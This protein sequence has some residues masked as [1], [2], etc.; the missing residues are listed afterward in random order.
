[1]TTTCPDAFLSLTRRS[2]TLQTTQ[3]T[4]CRVSEVPRWGSC[5]TKRN[6]K[7]RN[8]GPNVIG[9]ILDLDLRNH[10]QAQTEHGFESFRGCYPFQ[11]NLSE[12]SCTCAGIDLICSKHLIVTFRNLVWRHGQPRIDN[13][14]QESWFTNITGSRF[15][16]IEGSQKRVGTHDFKS[17]KHFLSVPVMWTLQTITGARLWH[18]QHLHTLEIYHRHLHFQSAPNPPGANSGRIWG[19]FKMHDFTKTNVIW[20]ILWSGSIHNITYKRFCLWGHS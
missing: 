13:R 2:K 16:A 18:R 10:L 12:L 11:D 15:V 5:E 1:M 8:K 14:S 19:G 6:S 20:L 17:E 3:R 7:W 9:K 4:Q